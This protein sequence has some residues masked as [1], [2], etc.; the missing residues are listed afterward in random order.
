MNNA[1]LLNRLKSIHL[2][3]IPGQPYK[4]SP[5]NR[6]LVENIFGKHAVLYY[7]NATN[8]ASKN[9][10]RK[11]FN[12]KLLELE[13]KVSRMERKRKSVFRSPA[14]PSQW[15]EKHKEAARTIKRIP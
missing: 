13:K 3:N 9:I 11:N 4:F 7:A 15:N 6:K 8:G 12:K 14:S 2:K 1:E 10:F 5:N